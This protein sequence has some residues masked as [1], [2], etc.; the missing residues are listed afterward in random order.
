MDGE[1]MF[2]NYAGNVLPEFLTGLWTI[3][4]D[5][6][7][8]RRMYADRTMLDILGVPEDTDP[9]GLYDLWHGGID[10]VGRK[11]A[12]EAFSEVMSGNAAE[13]RCT[14]HHPDQGDREVRFGGI[15]DRAGSTG[16]KTVIHGW[17]QDI[18]DLIHIH[19]E[20]AEKRR[21]TDISVALSEDYDSIYCVDLETDCY[22]QYHCRGWQK[23]EGTEASGKDF[24]NEAKRNLAVAAYE[25][26]KDTII[27]FIDKER[28]VMTLQSVS[29][30][31]TEYRLLIGGA[32]VY[33]R[34]KAILSHGGNTLI[35][36][37]ENIDDEVKAE[38]EKNKI[39]RRQSDMVDALSTRHDFVAFVNIY[40]NEM[41]VYKAEGIFSKIKRKIDKRTGFVSPADF[42]RMLRSVIVSDDFDQFLRDV[43][44]DRVMKR[45]ETEKQVFVEFRTGKDDRENWYKIGLTY[46]PEAGN[47]LIGI[48]N[49]DEEH[50]L[51]RQKMVIDNLSDDFE[52]IS[53][54]TLRDSATSDEIESFRVSPFIKERIPAWEET[55]H[56]H[57]RLDLLMKHVVYE[58][59]V[60]AFF[61][62]TRRAV[63]IENLE[64]NGFYFVNF[65]VLQEGRVK[66]YQ[67]KFAPEKRDGV[68]IGMIM[69]IHEADRQIKDE[70]RRETALAEANEKAEVTIRQQ[71]AELRKRNRELERTNEAI[72]DLLGDVVELRDSDSGKHVQRVKAFT[73]ILA[74]RVMRDCPEYGL[75]DEQVMLISSASALHD[76]G[77]IMIP[78]AILL[79]PGP[80][81]REEFEIMKT[82]CQKG[83]E[84]L[85]RASMDWNSK[86][87]E[88]GKEICRYHHEK[89]DG[90]GYPDG[91]KGDEIP[92]SAQIVSVADIYDALTSERIYKAAYDPE[93]AF[94]I[95]T[96]GGCGEFSD[97]IMNAFRKS[98]AG[99]EEIL[100]IISTDKNFIF[101]SDTLMT[102]DDGRKER[103]ESEYRLEDQLAVISSLGSDYDFIGSLNAETMELMVYHVDDWLKNMFDN[104]ED[105]IVSPEARDRTLQDIIYPDDFEIFK[106]K[107]MHENVVM[108]L[109]KDGVYYV[110]YRA[111]KYGDLIYYQTKYAL[112]RT[113][114][115]RIIIGLRSVDDHIR[116]DMRRKEMEFLREKQFLSENLEKV[117][118]LAN[119]DALTGA[120]SLTA[121]FEKKTE[122]DEK[123]TEGENVRF[124]VVECDTNNLKRVNDSYGHDA[125][126]VF[127]KRCY[128]IISEVLAGTKVYRIGGDEFVA[129]LEGALY[130][131][132]AAL[133]DE[134]MEK[135]KG[136]E[137]S[138]SLLNRTSFSCGFSEYEEGT[139][140]S[141]DDVFRRADQRLYTMKEDFK[142]KDNVL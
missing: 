9:A 14:F 122:I 108:K 134:L 19:R 70:I 72:I 7:G 25:K 71:T 139:D 16:E 142:A 65:R 46:D 35:V 58:P 81:T 42:D 54:I 90:G 11:T 94:E 56:I 12:E 73:R 41:E 18:T 102:D 67:M 83:C 59:D 129:I 44:R 84:V 17:H 136:G 100:G 62:A 112:D 77:K 5:K 51:A 40:R 119:R 82:H 110:N 55:K 130:D 86:Y 61:S 111:Y 89:W 52:C 93:T 133:I 39:L 131:S 38:K 57:D 29:S 53:Y 101:H 121:Y 125:G 88:I 91:L 138:E 132:R 3:E 64:K 49:S 92:I 85:D 45:F 28:L 127:I 60:N 87:L 98:R 32:P 43:D 103:K 6:D 117:T 20:S 120:G 96:S 106:K 75:D 116:S 66:Y 4:I 26:D 78:D 21:Q 50:F 104:I 27:N 15:L 123:I 36:A 10:P 109:M 135:A 105:L 115:R 99:F 76:I 1:T 24:F 34:A 47:V 107:S 124:A 2:P 140:L 63:I 33:F 97:K 48:R 79:K 95:I 30:V 22:T 141:V 74:E 8:T 13:I 137:E 114:P 80:L 126:N 68:I 118:A 128:R 113:N 69:G 23:R 31:T 37:V